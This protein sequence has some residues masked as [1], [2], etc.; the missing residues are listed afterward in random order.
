MLKKIIFTHSYYPSNFLKDMFSII[1]NE[2]LSSSKISTENAYLRFQN[3]ITKKIFK[4]TNLI[5]QKLIVNPGRIPLH[6]HENMTSILPYS[7]HFIDLVIDI[8]N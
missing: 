8:L 7:Y 5:L 1:Y 4:I 3:K 6:I 2:C